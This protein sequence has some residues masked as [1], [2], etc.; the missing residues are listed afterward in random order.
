VLGMTDGCY[1]ICIRRHMDIS[2]QN[3]ILHP[4][5]L[6][7]LFAFKSKSRRV[8]RDV[9]GIYDI[10]H[11][12]IAYIAHNQPLLTLS[13]TP[14]LEYNLFSSPLWRFDASFH[15]D[16][17]KQCQHASWQSLFA[18]ERFD[19]LYYIKHV[20]PRYPLG[21][22]IARPLN[23]GHVIYAIGASKNTIEMQTLFNTEPDKLCQLGQ[24][25]MTQLLDVFQIQSPGLSAPLK[26]PITG[27][28]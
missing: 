3:V 27:L 11:I 2:A 28:L 5:W 20:K 1:H 19:E 6:N 8:F 13:S 9:L 23:N 15:P 4:D 25:C 22:S 7:C 18:P 10:T 21:L 17:F 24:Y 26:T 16:W 14:S 12:A